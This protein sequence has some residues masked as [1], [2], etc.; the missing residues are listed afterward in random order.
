MTP[1]ST[2]DLLCPECGS[3][4]ISELD[5]EW[6]DRKLPH[7]NCIVCGWC[8]YHEELVTAADLAADA[9]DVLF[10]ERVD[11]GMA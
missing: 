6:R 3:P 2:F 7:A 11:R 8:G 5:H 9:G 1:H 10:H 4:E